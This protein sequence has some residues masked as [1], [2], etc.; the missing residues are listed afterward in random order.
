MLLFFHTSNGQQNSPSVEFLWEKIEGNLRR[1]HTEPFMHFRRANREPSMDFR[2]VNM[3]PSMHFRRA[4][5]ETYWKYNVN[6]SKRV[7]KDGVFLGLAE[8]LLRIS[9]RLR[10]REIPRSSTASPRKTPSFPPILLRLPIPVLGTK[11][12]IYIPGQVLADLDSTPVSGT[13]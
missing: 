1:A 8:L 12:T 9:L 10:P 5:T 6:L 3:E 2:K 11:Q 13:V 4:N 7:G